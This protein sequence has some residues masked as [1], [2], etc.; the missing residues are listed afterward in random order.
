M[1]AIDQSDVLFDNVSIIGSNTISSNVDKLGGTRVVATPA[2]N[3]GVGA[4]N[5]KYLSIS[6]GPAN[7]GGTGGTVALLTSDTTTGTGSSVSL[8]SP[9]TVWTS[10]TLVS[11]NVLANTPIAKFALFSYPQILSYIQL[12]WTPTTSGLTSGSI[13]AFISS[14]IQEYNRSVMPVV[15]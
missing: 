1:S 5:P 7:W 6:A 3:Y 11:S 8:V 12:Q 4:G 2:G 9:T 10:P 13:N 14:D 15:G